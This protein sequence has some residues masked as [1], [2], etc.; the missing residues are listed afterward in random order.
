[1]N[2]NFVSHI[3]CFLLSLLG[4]YFLSCFI[5]MEWIN[6]FADYI[7]KDQLSGAVY[8]LAWFLSA[9]ALSIK[10]D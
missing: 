1:M 3:I 10:Y 7:S 8:R 2:N 6:P 4:L 5:C 9:G